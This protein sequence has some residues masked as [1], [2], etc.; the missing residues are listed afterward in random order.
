MPSGEWVFLSH[1]WG[2]SSPAYGGGE[3]IQVVPDRQIKQGDTSNTLKFAASNHIGT[4]IDFPLHFLADGKSATEYP[5][6]FFVFKSAAVVWLENLPRASHISVQILQEYFSK[7]LPPA[8][9]EILLL[10]T[11]ASLW[12]HEDD[13]V[14]Q[15]IGIGLDVADFVRKRMPRLRAI[16]MDMISTTSFANRP[17]GREVHKQMLAGDRPICLIEDMDLEP[18]QGWRGF[19][20]VVLPLR[21]E[22]A[23]GAPCTIIARRS[24]S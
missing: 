6:D 13:F 5:A 10:R 4:H 12:R 22:G 21:I 7:H 9:T 8:D 23:D 2:P 14:F 3:R 11:G 17:L 18:L 16:G 20:V 19:E 15:N 1:L 24:N